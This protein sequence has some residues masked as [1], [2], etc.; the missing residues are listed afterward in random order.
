MGTRQVNN[1]GIQEP[2]DFSQGNF[3]VSAPSE[4]PISIAAHNQ[5]T[6]TSIQALAQRNQKVQQHSLS[7]FK[8]NRVSSRGTS[9]D[10]YTSFI[11]KQQSS[12][13]SHYNVSSTHVKRRHA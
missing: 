8:K 1:N 12:R 10:N 7:L 6:R 5:M 2:T 9:R 4:N 11:N 13:A 3:V